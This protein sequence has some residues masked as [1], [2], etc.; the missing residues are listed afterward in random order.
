MTK[1]IY[2]RLK[3]EFPK[4]ALSKDTSRGFELTSVKA[5]YIIERLNEV[6]GIGGWQL[7]GEFTDHPNGVLYFGNLHIML[8]NDV[9][10]TVEAIGFCGK[11][12]NIGDMYKSARTDAL[13]K[14]ASQVGVANS[15]FKGLDVR[16]MPAEPKSTYKP[17]A[18]NST[19]S[20]TD[21][22]KRAMLKRLEGV[23]TQAANNI[24]KLG[25]PPSKWDDPT[26]DAVAEL[27]KLA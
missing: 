22:Q 17:R 19:G 6:L 23:N 1:E 18:K 3:A 4:E 24:K 5:Q 15:V 9:C 25:V 20:Y 26:W 21:E 14:A 16:H 27:T 11:K 7:K 10:H 13:S 2:D 8:P 12:K